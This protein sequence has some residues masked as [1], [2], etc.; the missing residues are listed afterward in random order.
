MVDVDKSEF[1]PTATGSARV[2]ALFE[3]QS[4]LGGLDALVSS[5]GSISSLH[6][7]GLTDIARLQLGDSMIAL[8]NRLGQPFLADTASI[9]VANRASIESFS[10]VL[11]RDWAMNDSLLGATSSFL[12][13]DVVAGLRNDLYSRH[14][15]SSSAWTSALSRGFTDWVA[16]LDGLEP[17]NWP[18]EVDYRQLAQIALND[19]I[20]VVWVL[21]APA[22]EQVQEL[23]GRDDRLAAVLDNQ[24]EILALCRETLNAIVEPDVADARDLAGEALRALESGHTAPAQALAVNVLDTILNKHNLPLNN[25]KSVAELCAFDPDEIMCR[26]VILRYAIAP[27]VRFATQWHPENPAP[28]PAALSRH[29]SI[30][31]ADARQYS[32]INSLVAVMLL[33]SYLRTYQDERDRESRSRTAA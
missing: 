19:G 6:A 32:P 2:A 20:P 15:T 3:T 4:A 30:H 22:V 10:S 13:D 8:S 31:G 25:A 26:D 12:A 1:S 33:I 27:F 24:T 11:A 29:V 5:L 16:L 21:P 9:Q 17:P 23:R 7:T 18:E 14:L 28:K